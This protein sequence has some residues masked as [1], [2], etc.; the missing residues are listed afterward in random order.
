MGKRKG[1]KKKPPPILPQV[2]SLSQ[3]ESGSV[4]NAEIVSN[5]LKCFLFPILHQNPTREINSLYLK[6]PKKA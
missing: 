5:F 4:S 2:P 6:N 1:K 3:T